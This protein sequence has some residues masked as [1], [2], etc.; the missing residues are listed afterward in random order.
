MRVKGNVVGYEDPPPTTGKR[1]VP[2]KY[3]EKLKPIE[4]FDD[5]RNESDLSLIGT[6][7]E[8]LIVQASDA[9]EGFVNFGFFATGILQILVLHFHQGILKNYRGWLRTVI[10]AIP[11]EETVRSV[12]QE[13]FFHIIKS[14][15]N[16]LLKLLSAKFVSGSIRTF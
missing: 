11:F 4:F 9:I 12:V 2:R 1:E 13:E 7:P 10:S 3:S 6:Q 5:K 16:N 8:N 14:Q 15:F